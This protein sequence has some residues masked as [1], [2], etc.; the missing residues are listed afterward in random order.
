MPTNAIG[1]NSYDNKPIPKRNEMG[2]PV[3]ELPNVKTNP[4][5]KGKIKSSLF[6]EMQYVTIGDKYTD[7]Y[8]MR[9]MDEMKKKSL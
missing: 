8:K 9:M 6:S 1:D 5:K 3:T 4:P 7:E 2:K